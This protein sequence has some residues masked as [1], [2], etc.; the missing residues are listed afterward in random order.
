MCSSVD[1]AKALRTSLSYLEKKRK[2]QGEQLGLPPLKHVCSNQTHNLKYEFLSNPRSKDQ[3]SYRFATIPELN[4]IASA[5][6]SEQESAK[7]SNSI[8]ADADSMISVSG[9]AEYQ[10]Y[11]EEYSFHQ[12]SSSS[13]YSMGSLSKSTLHSLET[14]STSKSSEKMET[15]PVE[16]EHDRDHPNFGLHDSMNYED[17]LLEFGG[18]ADFSCSEDRSSFEDCIDKEL[19]NM[20]YSNGVAPNN[21]VLSSGRWS[22]KQGNFL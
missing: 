22:V 1:I 3:V 4:G 13:V 17:H 5:D 8:G 9:E 20:L 10:S 19:E 11:S 7:D 15:L 21:Y 2:L 14:G 12:P 16:K 6:E 18:H